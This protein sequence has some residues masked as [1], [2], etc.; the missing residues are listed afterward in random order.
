MKLT[1]L[2]LYISLVKKT[3]V[4]K[5]KKPTRAELQSQ[6][7]AVLNYEPDTLTGFDRANAAGL[8]KVIASVTAF[9]LAIDNNNS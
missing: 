9:K 3:T 6:L 2:N 4:K 5:D 7:E 1:S 8:L